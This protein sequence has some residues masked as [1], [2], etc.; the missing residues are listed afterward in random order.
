MAYDELPCPVLVT[1]AAGKIL[2]ANAELLAVVAATAQQL[3]Q[4]SIEL[5]LPP[6]SRI[7]LQT[8]I[9]PMLLRDAQ[10]QEIH[11]KL[12]SMDHRRI[13]VM[14][15]CKKRSSS[16]PGT[17]SY[18]WVFFVANERS[19]FEENLLQARN[20]AEAAAAA[21]ADREAF[22]KTITDA[23]PG[24]VAYYDKHL[25]CRFVNQPGIDGYAGQ[26]AL[27]P[28]ASMQDAPGQPTSND[29]HICGVLAGQRQTFERTVRLA[30]G[31]L[32][33]TLA[34]Y[35]PDLDATGNVVGFFILDTDITP[36]KSAEFELRLAA[37]I[38]ESTVEGIMV[39][40][41]EGIILSVN[42]AFSA[43]TG[44]SAGE[45]MGQRADMLASDRH[46]DLFH[47]AMARTI[48]ADGRWEGE[49]W[50]RRKDGAIFLT[51]QSTTII[52]STADDPVRHV[53]IFNDISELWKKNENTRY[54]AFHDSLT[55][56]PNRSLLMDRMAQLIA[57]TDREHCNVAV[58]FL[59][60][61]GFKRVN[62]TLGHATGDDLLV[63]VATRLL[64]Q[65]RQVDT[66]ARLGGDEFVIML[67][68][69]VGN[70]EVTQ[71]AARIIESI[72]E[73][74]HF[75][76]TTVKV[77]IS[78]GIAMHADNGLTPNKLLKSADG[79]MYQ[80]KAAG[81]NTF[82]FCQPGPLPPGT[83]EEL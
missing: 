27:M 74:M 24:L 28:G 6:A 39:T 58:M 73:P 71:I 54:L 36:V 82:V 44:Y 65:V 19:K 26:P 55:G 62:D 79:A 76:P 37:S 75:G 34:N 68:N 33:Y 46:D 81:K 30:D 3:R 69:P 52:G 2:S 7:F 1:D 47:A 15:N 61:D 20:V 13:P 80:A 4:Q 12:S 40:D 42:P 8:H 72:N 9:W 51:W 14:V 56:L 21:L 43:I 70:D 29:P 66:V 32:A 83:C 22:I 35:I 64:A 77:G 45:V 49:K 53:S 11:L 25:H 63:V 17:D 48:A 60:L 10:V 18:V 16:T 38:F 59:D 41:A 78:I 23:M 50:H 57:R 67:D 5:L 31:S